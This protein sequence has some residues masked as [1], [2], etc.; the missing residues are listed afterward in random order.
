M[1]GC[2]EHLPI[3]YVEISKKSFKVL[4]YFSD[5]ICEI[6]GFARLNSQCR[7]ISV[8]QNL[9]MYPH[10]PLTLSPLKPVFMC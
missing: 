1:F 2:V 3:Q 8:S 5:W 6:F 10:Q 9:D 4:D 7:P